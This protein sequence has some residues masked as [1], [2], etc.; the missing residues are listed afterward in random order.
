MEIQ[1]F[2]LGIWLVCCWYVV[3]MLWFSYHRYGRYARYSGRNSSPWSTIRACRSPGRLVASLPYPPS[4]PSI[5]APFTTLSALEVHAKTHLSATLL[6][7]HTLS[8]RH[9]R[10]LDHGIEVYQ[11][12]VDSLEEAAHGGLNLT[13]GAADLHLDLLD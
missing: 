6:P 4:P 13:V 7:S 3:G 5:T 8:R 9:V 12:I 10:L 2:R 1:N 11:Q